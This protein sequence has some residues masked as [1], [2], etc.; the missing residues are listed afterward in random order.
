MSVHRN[1]GLKFLTVKALFYTKYIALNTWKYTVF[2]K[3][4]D[5]L[6]VSLYSN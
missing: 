2:T 3:S 4:R 6:T 1:T 5:V